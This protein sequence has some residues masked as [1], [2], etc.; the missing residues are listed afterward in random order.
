MSG[1]KRGKYGR[2]IH[3]ILTLCD[4]ILVNI[5]F[6]GISFVWNLFGADGWRTEWLLVNVSYIPVVYWFARSRSQRTLHIDRIYVSALQ[7]VGIHAL[8][9]L[10]MLAFIGY[11]LTTTFIAEFYGAMLLCLPVS[12]TTSRMILKSLRKSGR[13]FSKVV[14]VG[15]GE[16]A[17]RLYDSLLSDAGYGYNVIGFFDYGNHGIPEDKYLGS[18]ENL[19]SFVGNHSVDEIF[20][21]LSGERWDALRSVVRV[22]DENMAKFYYVPQIS[23][24]IGRRLEMG[25]IGSMSVLSTLYNPLSSIYNLA[26]KRGFDIVFSAIALLLSPIV[27]IPVAIAIKI[28]SPGPVFFRQLRTGYR[29]REFYCWKFRTMR[30]NADADTVQATAG[31]PRKTRVGDFLRRTSIDELPQFINVFLGDMSVV[32]PRPHML[33][34]TEEYKRLIGRYMVRHMVKPGITGWA[35]IHGFRGPTDEL[36]KM[37]ARVDHDVWYIENWSFFLDLKIIVKTIVNAIRGEKNAC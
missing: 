10:S 9:F 31:D 7:A 8:C 18:I 34:H 5:L 29:G 11:G 19:E 30:V 35:Q 24:F 20:Y 33:R 26:L 17:K 25:T 21:T 27:F 22:A 6:V 28:S 12:W 37:E 13:N 16:T 2:Y 32:G 3:N 23:R 15:T 36:W 14:I 1:I 4:I